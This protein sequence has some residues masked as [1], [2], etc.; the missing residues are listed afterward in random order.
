MWNKDAEVLTRSSVKRDGWK[1]SMSSGTLAQFGSINSGHEFGCSDSVFEVQAIGVYSLNGYRNKRE[2]NSNENKNVCW[3]GW[4]R[5]RLG[6]LKWNSGFE[7]LVFT[8][9]YFPYHLFFFRSF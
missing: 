7:F 4:L 2:N 9:F 5:I 3:L 6:H 1:I 8:W